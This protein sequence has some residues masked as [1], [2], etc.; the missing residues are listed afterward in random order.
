MSEEL[1]HCAYSGHEGQNP[2]PLSQFSKRSAS[3]DGRQPVCREC[4]RR[5]SADWRQRHGGKAAPDAAARIAELNRLLRVYQGAFA[6]LD[7]GTRARL[8]AK[9]EELEADRG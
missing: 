5:R 7:E 1:K 4:A 3:P 9:I 8:K 6:E 2:L